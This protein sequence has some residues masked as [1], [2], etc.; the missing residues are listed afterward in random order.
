MIAD[1]DAILDALSVGGKV[2]NAAFAQRGS[3]VFIILRKGATKREVMHEI[4]HML[5][6][7]KYGPEYWKLSE[8]ARERLASTFVRD[9]SLWK[10]L[11]PDEQWAELENILSEL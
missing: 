5:A 6:W 11:L 9:S 3:G 8:A 10:R 4:G 2:K 7:K 1:G